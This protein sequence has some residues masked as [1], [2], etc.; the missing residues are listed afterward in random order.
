LTSFSMKSLT[1]LQ[2]VWIFLK[3]EPLN[4]EPANG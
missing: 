2:A 3:P 4:P 1:Q